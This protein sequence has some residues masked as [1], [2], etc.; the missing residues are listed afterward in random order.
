M[1]NTFGE[2]EKFKN[3]N[4]EINF[5]NLFLARNLNFKK[6][7]VGFFKSR[8]FYLFVGLFS[9]KSLFDLIKKNKPDYLII[10]LLTFI[11]L[12]LLMFFNF[13]TKF[14]L[15][16]SGFPKLNLFRRTLW[17]LISKKI[18]KV[19]CPTEETMKLL[20][21]KKIFPENKFF[22]LE[23]PVIEISK[24]IK[25][26]NKKISKL[27]ENKKFILAIGRLSFQKNFQLLLNFFK[28]ES[29][30]DSDLFL[31]IAG[32][33]EQRKKIENFIIKNELENKIILLG[34]ESNIHNLLK[35][36]Y[37]FILTSLWEDPGFALLEAAA[38]DASIISSDCSSGPK[39]ILSNGKGGLL[40]TSESIDSLEKNFEKFKKLNKKEIYLQKISSKKMAIKYTKFRHFKKLN[41]F[42]NE[43]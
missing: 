37:C 9:I 26:R 24:I 39:E 7:I 29:K 25:L 12:F 20:I 28:R 8:M 34:Y 43:N 23:D 35:K 32:E 2:W 18:D 19:F 42:L 6:N 14:I 13:K 27:L 38:N 10:H 17:K 41:I 22:L 40:F 16:I 33:G 5:I 30:K 21:S 1:I 4:K 31:V 15:R 3:D 36:C 11:P